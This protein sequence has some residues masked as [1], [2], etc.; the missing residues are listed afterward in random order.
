MESMK[1]K[2]MVFTSKQSVTKVIAYDYEPVPTDW[3]YV[4][5]VKGTPYRIRLFGIEIKMSWKAR[6][7][8]FAGPIME[9]YKH[10]VDYFKFFSI[11]WFNVNERRLYYRPR[12]EIWKINPD[13]MDTTYFT[14]YDS[15][16]LYARIMEQKYDLICNEENNSN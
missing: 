7:T 10:D 16:L 5:Q 14:D 4:K 11:Y 2:K 6:E 8:K 9:Q 15:A 3:L 12:V 13:V 1:Y